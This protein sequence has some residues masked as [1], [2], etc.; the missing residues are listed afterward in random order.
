MGL[1]HVIL[2]VPAFKESYCSF[3]FE[4]QQHHTYSSCVYQDITWKLGSKWNDV[5]EIFVFF[6]EKAWVNQNLY[7][8]CI[9][10]MLPVIDD[11]DRRKCWTCDSWKAHTASKLKIT[12]FHGILNVVIVGNNDQWLLGKHNVSQSDTSKYK[13]VTR[14]VAIVAGKDIMKINNSHKDE[15]IKS[16]ESSWQ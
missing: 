13:G 1:L 7:N 5:R 8:K 14:D 11:K 15:F 3:V 16:N 9:D 10:V 6:N 2:K 12:L 4:A